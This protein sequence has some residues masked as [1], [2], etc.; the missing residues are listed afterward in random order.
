ML[1]SGCTL[2][3][4]REAFFRPEILD[5]TAADLRWGRNRSETGREGRSSGVI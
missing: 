2:L 3:T 4:I 5:R 1:V